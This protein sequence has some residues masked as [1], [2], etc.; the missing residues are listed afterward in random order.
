MRSE[1][2][3]VSGE[4]VCGATKFRFAVWN[5]TGSLVVPKH[6]LICG[7]ELASETDQSEAW[8]VA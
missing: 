5:R 2:R 3:V 4:W 1:D 8:L 7:M 6:G